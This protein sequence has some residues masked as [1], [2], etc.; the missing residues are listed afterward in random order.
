MDPFIFI[1]STESITMNDYT[2]PN[3]VKTCAIF[4]LLTET[5]K[6]LNFSEIAKELNLPRTS[7]YRILK[8]LESEQMVRKV[9]KG[10]VMGDHTARQKIVV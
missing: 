3:I 1:H 6:A 8:T 4:Q 2:T 9:G 7:V 5:T 10:F